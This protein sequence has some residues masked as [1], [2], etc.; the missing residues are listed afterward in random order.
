MPVIRSV[1]NTSLRDFNVLF[2]DIKYI[3]KYPTFEILSSKS[4]V[5]NKWLNE[6]TDVVGD[7]KRHLRRT[8]KVFHSRVRLCS[9]VV[10]IT[11]LQYNI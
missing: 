5:A 7:I 6:T 10:F 8:Q 9:L 2:Y 3:S 4:L 11:M 1:V